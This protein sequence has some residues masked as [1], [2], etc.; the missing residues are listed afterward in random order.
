M[1]ANDGRDTLVDLTKTLSEMSQKRKIAPAEVTTEL[2]HAEI[3]DATACEEPDLLVVMGEP[4]ESG[5][6]GKRFKR[7]KRKQK[8]VSVGT[9][10]SS[11]S[12]TW[13]GAGICL[14]GYPPWQVR[15]T[16]IL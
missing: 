16:E 9:E 14:R 13:S 12:Q 3:E 11:V 7:N 5:H 8:S 2:I 15:L 4:A 1:S 6:V 10:V